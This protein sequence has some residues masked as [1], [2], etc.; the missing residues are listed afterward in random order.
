MVRFLI[1]ILCIVFATREIYTTDVVV[2]SLSHKFSDYSHGF[3][4]LSHSFSSA[5]QSPSEK[6]IDI[7][8]R[9]HGML[10]GSNTLKFKDNWE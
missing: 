8:A 3:S 1:S 5:S 10:K 6:T 2:G 9:S 4:T 7:R